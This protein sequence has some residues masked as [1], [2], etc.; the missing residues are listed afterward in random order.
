MRANGKAPIGA[1]PGVGRGGGRGVGGVSP[2]ARGG[3]ARP[4]GGIVDTAGPVTN[5]AGVKITNALSHKHTH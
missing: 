4:A 5:S 1:I 2:V 3:G